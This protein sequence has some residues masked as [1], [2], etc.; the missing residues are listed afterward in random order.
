MLTEI[1]HRLVLMLIEFSEEPIAAG[2]ISRRFLVMTPIAGVANL[3]HPLSV[4]RIRGGFRVVFAVVISTMTSRI[5]V[6]GAETSQV[7]SERHQ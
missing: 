7:L 5:F 3:N 2:L 6:V 1:P 4:R